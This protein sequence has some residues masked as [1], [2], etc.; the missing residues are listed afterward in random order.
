MGKK[1][2]LTNTRF[3]SLVAV[4]PFGSDKWHCVCDCGNEKDIRTYNLTSGITTSCGRCKCIDL[5][6]QT[7]NDW[8]VIK[9]IGKNR[10]EC[11][12][13]CGNPGK[14]STIDLLRGRSKSCGHNTNKFK[15]ITGIKFGKWTPIKYIGDKHWWCKCDCGHEQSIETSALT[16]GLT[17]M[18]LECRGKERIKNLT[19]LTFGDWYVLGLS[20]NNKDKHNTYWKCRC[21]KCKKIKDVEGY[22]L[23]SGNSTNCG[24]RHIVDLVGQKFGEWTVIKRVENNKWE[25]QCSCENKTIRNLSTSALRLGLSKSCGCKQAENRKNT[26][27][28]RYGELATSRINKPRDIERVEIFKSKEN[29]E[30]F[31]INLTTEIGHKPTS[32]EIADRLD[33]TYHS[34]NRKL[35]FFNL[36]DFII[37]GNTHSSSYESSL[38]NFIKSKTDE[39]VLTNFRDIPGVS[40]IDIY[41]PGKKLAIEINGDYWHSSLFKDKIYHQEKTI[42]CAKQGI[43]LIHIFEYEWLNENTREKLLHMLESIINPSSNKVLYARNTHTEHIDK[44]SCSD[45]LNQYHLQSSIGSYDNISLIDSNNDIVGVL[46]FGKPRFSNSNYDYEIYRLV[47]KSGYAISGGA[48]KLFSTFIKEYKPNNIIT[49]CDITKF[50]GNV[51]T[52]LGFKSI[53]ITQPNYVWVKPGR[54]EYI[55]R[56]GTMKKDLIADGLD[57][58]GS[59]EDEIMENIGYVKVYNSGN[60]KFEWEVIR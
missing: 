35:A 54:G 14:V 40:E 56:Y 27:L 45:F 16:R 18:C 29:L 5:K 9:Y 47:F 25:C 12:C 37:V 46:T 3:G 43:R 57:I 1:I 39:V 21:L 7:I 32:F 52:R 13:S 42:A 20:D 53:K 4:Y 51:Y 38:L 33:V 41:I 2:D 31:I 36:K 58:Y 17:T 11:V 48:E 23:T 34:V 55:S 49:Y 59:S 50:T 28:D 10:W 6:G 60:I 26:M 15:D 19:G 30:A 8:T 24:C 22:S 44:K